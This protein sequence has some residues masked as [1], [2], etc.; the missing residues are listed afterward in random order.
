LDDYFY[1]LAIS[2]ALGVDQGFSPRDS[3]SF[4][5]DVLSIVELLGMAWVDPHNTTISAC[6]FFCSL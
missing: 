5:F 4:P 3:T 6:P 2:S 1:L